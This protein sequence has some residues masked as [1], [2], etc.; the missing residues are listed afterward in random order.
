MINELKSGTNI[1]RDFLL[2][3]RENKFI[4]EQIT[5]M[6]MGEIPK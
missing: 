2:A 6:N 3:S 1:T 4:T 5:N